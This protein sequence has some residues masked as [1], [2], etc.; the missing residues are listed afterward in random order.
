MDLDVT[1]GRIF[2]V[3]QLFRELED[4]LRFKFASTVDTKSVQ[5][6]AS[7]QVLKQSMILSLKDQ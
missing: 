3:Y 5:T 7:R 6:T 2:K 1:A 4:L